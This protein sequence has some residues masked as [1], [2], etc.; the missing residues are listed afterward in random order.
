MMFFAHFIV[1]RDGQTN[2]AFRDIGVANEHR[3]LGQRVDI[4]FLGIGN[5]TASVIG[6]AVLL[7]LSA[8]QYQ[9]ACSA[10]GGQR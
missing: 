6:T 10:I 1:E 4:G 5:Q 8:F 2:Q 9:M 3:Q 7:E